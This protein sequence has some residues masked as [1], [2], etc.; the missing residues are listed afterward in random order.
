MGLEVAIKHSK[1]WAITN[2]SE[3][4]ADVEQMPN[5]EMKK[6][7]FIRCNGVFN[8]KG[9]LKQGMKA[10]YAVKDKKRAFE[11]II[12]TVQKL[13]EKSTITDY[14]E[15]LVIKEIDYLTTVNKIRRNK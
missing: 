4:R 7:R 8:Y 10:E 1:G 5:G 2:E 6:K 15:F 9:D 3:M 14:V 13:D 12:T 11:G